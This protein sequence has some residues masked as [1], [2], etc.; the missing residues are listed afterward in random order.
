MG[1]NVL[2]SLGINAIWYLCGI[3]G[4]II[5]GISL[6]IALYLKKLVD[7]SLVVLDSI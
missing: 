6:L 3:L 7:E 1:S 2:A 4:G 5:L